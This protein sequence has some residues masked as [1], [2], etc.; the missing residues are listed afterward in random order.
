MDY[1]VGQN[2]GQY[3]QVS[4]MQFSYNFRG[5]WV[6][7]RRFMRGSLRGEARYIKGEEETFDRV[8]FVKCHLWA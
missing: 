3:M 4:G 5:Q 6:T 8:S 7:L 1:L 2:R